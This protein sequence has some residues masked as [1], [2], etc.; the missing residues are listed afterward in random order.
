MTKKTGIKNV[1]DE[2][3]R[4]II[5]LLINEPF[6]AHFLSGIIRNITTDVPTAAVGLLNGKV[7]LF[8][9][10]EFFLKE[11]TTFSNRV[12]VI[13]HETLHLLFKHL[14]RLDKSKYDHRLYN[15]AADIVVNQFIGKWNLPDSA[16]TLSTFPD[17]GLEKDKNL[18][19][20]Y[21]KL[22]ELKSKLNKSKGQVSN[23]YHMS[24]P[25]SAQALEEVLENQN[26][27]DHSK[28]YN[29]S[30]IKDFSNAEVDLDRLIVQAKDRTSS[31]NYGSLPQEIR[32]QIT[33]IIDQRNPKINWRRA[34]KIFS[35]SSKKTRVKYTLKKTSKRYGTIPGIHI[36]RSQKMAVAI[37]TSGSISLNDFNVFFSEIHFMWKSGAEI[38]IIECDAVVQR[39][40][41]Y[42]GILPREIQGRGGTLFDP[43]FS[44]LNK[45]RF[46]RYDGCVFLTDGFAKEPIIKPHCKL[47]WVITSDGQTG[48]H[49]KFGQVI[50]IV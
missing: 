21:F 37:D 10:E 13:K 34:L 33:L 31:E 16:V 45:D 14:F 17:L 50:Q 8:I 19:W 2:I 48:P 12:A 44:Y 3:S 22:S 28:W 29:I 41:P 38:E 6:Y 15:I 46:K 23:S 43:V 5:Q 40:Y 1:N 30:Q 4:C 26:H 47:L 42:Q 25:L 36:K 18:E 39:T 49:L 24:S 27:S 32:E 11:L 35:S 20:Y 9:N 7:N